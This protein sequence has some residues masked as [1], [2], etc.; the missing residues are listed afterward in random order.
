MNKIILLGVL[1][2]LLQVGL[3][4]SSLFAESVYRSVNEN[5]EVV[6]SSKPPLGAKNVESIQLQPGPLESDVN[7]AKQRA[8]G[9]KQAIKKSQQREKNRL[10]D[11]R[12]VDSKLNSLAEAEKKL[13]KAK[14]IQDSDWQFLA[15]GGRHL[16]PAYFERIKKAEAA[17]ER[18]KKEL[19]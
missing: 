6:Y 18:A 11:K 17:Y 10:I 2:L 14:V 15:R 12:K 4:S 16:K 19:K 13:Q 7:A 1:L 9:L 3:Y 8:I 5:G